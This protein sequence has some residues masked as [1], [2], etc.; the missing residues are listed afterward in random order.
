M[1]GWTCEY[2][3]LIDADGSCPC[4]A[5]ADTDSLSDWGVLTKYLT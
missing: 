2:G 3:H 1:D 5:M 4:T